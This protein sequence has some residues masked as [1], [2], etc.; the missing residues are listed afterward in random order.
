MEDWIQAF[1]L[2]T[3]PLALACIGMG[4]IIAYV[5]NGFQSTIFLLTLLTAFLLQILSNLANDYG[6]SMNGADSVDRVGPSRAVQTGKISAE[7]MKRAMI[8]FAVLSFASGLGLLYLSIDTPQEFYIFLG[9]GIVC[10]IAAIT[11][12]VGKN[13]YGYAGLGDIS[14]LLFFGLVSVVGTYYLQM[15]SLGW[16]IILPAISCG[17]FAVGVLNVNNIRDIESDEKAGKYSIPVRLGREKA[18][19]YHWFLLAAGWLSAMLYVVN[20]YS[21]YW[22]W[23]FVVTL[24]LFLINAKAVFTK[25]DAKELDP[26]LKQMAIS[27]LI[28]VIVFGIG[29]YLGM[30]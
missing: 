18:V 5:E 12:T 1:R 3:L 28:F 13:P 10:V 6:D 14:V 11:Y 22:Q 23:L 24:P 16:N 25:K 15:H 17:A 9:M 20:T 8:L 21:S 27:T 7:A 26:Y 2:R 29:Q 4:G 30:N 19:Y